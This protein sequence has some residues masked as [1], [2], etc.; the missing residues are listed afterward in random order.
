M[1]ADELFIFPSP[2][3]GFEMPVFLLDDKV[4]DV[5]AMMAVAIKDDIPFHTTKAVAIERLLATEQAFTSISN[6]LV[7]IPI[8]RRTEG[9]ITYRILR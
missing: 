3:A 9:M 1:P 4:E 5:E 7:N 6:W 2:D 8:D